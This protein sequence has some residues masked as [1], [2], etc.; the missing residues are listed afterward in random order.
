MADESLLENETSVGVC[1]LVFGRSD[2]GLASCL[3]SAVMAGIESER[4]AKSTSNEYQ[5]R[6]VMG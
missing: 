1:Q 4:N 5:T 3:R 2:R 6:K